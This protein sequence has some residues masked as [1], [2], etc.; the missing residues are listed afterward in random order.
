MRTDYYPPGPIA[1][2]FID[3][4]SFVC[5]IKGPVGSGKSVASVIKLLKLAGKQNRSPRDG[6]RHSRFA[7]IRNTYPE[8]KTTTIKTFHAWVPPEM[9]KWRDEGP[10]TQFIQTDELD[11]EVLFVA[12]D[13]PADVRKLLSLEFVFLSYPVIYQR[14]DIRVLEAIHLPGIC[15]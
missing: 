11:I 14:L 15:N 12:L 1:A 6:K 10:P 8:L 5:G 2:A 13:R 9:G 4:E 3:D 7:I